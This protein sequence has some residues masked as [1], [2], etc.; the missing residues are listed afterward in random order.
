M[1]PGS[2]IALV[3][4]TVF[5]VGCGARSAPQPAVKAP[6][7]PC[8]SWIIMRG[9]RDNPDEAFVCQSDPR[10]NCVVPVS[11]TG[12]QVFSNVYV[13]YHGAGADTKYTG[14]IQIGFFAGP[15]G[16]LS[17]AGDSEAHRIRVVRS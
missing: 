4:A 5:A 12:A 9:N 8:V 16:A 14:S 7:T 6:G 3:I 10:N 2:L 17:V 1:R 13:Y 11:R 15:G